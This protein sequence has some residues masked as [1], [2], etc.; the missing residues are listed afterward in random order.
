MFSG[1]HYGLATLALLFGTLPL[2]AAEPKKP[3]L[4]VLVVFDQMRGDFVDKWRPLFVEDG[5][6]RL[7]KEGAWYSNCHYPYA[8]T[9]TGVGHASM[10]TG[11]TPNQH[12]IINNQWYDVRA[13]AS[14]NCSQSDRYQRVPALVKKEPE[15][16][17][18]KKTETS[19]SKSRKGSGTPDRLLVPT[20]GDA[21]K[22]STQGKA[23]VFG[24]SFK[25]R[26]AELPKKFR[27]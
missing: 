27:W 26:S 7:Q 13:G 11:C 12:G 24:L 5:F 8:T 9:T 10:L 23:K 25:D 14:V 21:L 4:L 1:R 17:E 15:P 6:R 2:L 22:E 19:E 18:P 3:Q 16:S 20:V